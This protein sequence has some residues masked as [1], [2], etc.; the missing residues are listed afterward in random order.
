MR[1]INFPER[2]GGFID[3]DA[4]DSLLPGAATLWISGFIDV[5]ES[6]VKLA[7]PRVVSTRLSLMSDRSFTSYETAF[8]HVTGPKLAE[9][10]TVVWDQTMSTCCSNI[11]S[12]PTIR[13][14][15][16]NPGSPAWAS[17]WSRSCDFCLPM[18]RSALS[19]TLAIPAWFIWTHAGIR[20][21]SVLST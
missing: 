14:F 16:S 4:T 5:Y 6:G 17:T 1:D 13:N 15:R 11:P 19:N 8:A 20:P 21:R 7:E 18:A 9:D 12:S 10:T 3:I 2:G